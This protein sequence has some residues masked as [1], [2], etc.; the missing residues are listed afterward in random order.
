M[1]HQ[2][3]ADAVMQLVSNPAHDARSA[4]LTG[5]ESGHSPSLSY[6]A[7]TAQ[8]QTTLK[9]GILLLDPIV[10]VETSID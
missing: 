6:Q 2:L 1:V 4:I 5:I 9:S 3:N 10:T 8:T 7:T